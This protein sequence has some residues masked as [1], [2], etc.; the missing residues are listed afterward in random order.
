MGLH[1]LEWDH[2]RFVSL[3]RPVIQRRSSSRC[4]SLLQRPRPSSTNCAQAP[5][6]IP[7]DAGVVS[8]RSRRAADPEALHGYRRIG[9]IPRRRGSTVHG[10]LFASNLVLH[11]GVD[12]EHGHFIA[13]YGLETAASQSAPLGL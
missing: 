3:T 1:E 11:S 13:A 8:P 10:L 7:T 4:L 6:S 9:T 2:T 5:L 12:D